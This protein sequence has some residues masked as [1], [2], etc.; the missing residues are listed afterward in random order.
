MSDVAPPESR[1]D[2][3]PVI[4]NEPTSHNTIKT[5]PPIATATATATATAASSSSS[6]SSSSRHQSSSSS[7]SPVAPSSETPQ[8]CE[9]TTGPRKTLQL[10]TAVDSALASAQTSPGTKTPKVTP[11]AT[12]ST[13]QLA[14]EALSTIP[15]QQESHA[16]SIVPAAARLLSAL[17]RKHK[18]APAIQ[19]PRPGSIRSRSAATT[20]VPPSL[21]HGLKHD[22]LDLTANSSRATTPTRTPSG[23]AKRQRRER[24][25]PTPSA[26]PSALPSL[27]SNDRRRSARVAK[28]V[29]TSTSDSPN[30]PNLALFQFSPYLENLVINTKETDRRTRSAARG[31]RPIVDRAPTR[32]K[33]GAAKSKTNEPDQDAP[34][35]EAKAELYRQLCTISYQL[36]AHLDLMPRKSLEQLSAQFATPSPHENADEHANLPTTCPESAVPGASANASRTNTPAPNLNMQNSYHAQNSYNP[37]NQAN[38]MCSQQQPVIIK[39]EPPQSPRFSHL[40]SQ[41]T[42]SHAHFESQEPPKQAYSPESSPEVALAQR[43]RPPASTYNY[44]APTY[45]KVDQIQDE[46]MSPPFRPARRNI[47]SISALIHGPTRPTKPRTPSPQLIRTPPPPVAPQFMQEWTDQDEMASQ[48]L[49]ACIAAIPKLDTTELDRLTQIAQLAAFHLPLPSAPSSPRTSIPPLLEQD[50]QARLEAIAKY[51]PRRLNPLDTLDTTALYSAEESDYLSEM[52][53]N[54]ELYQSIRYLSSFDAVV[55]EWRAG[56]LMRLRFQLERRKAEID[57]IW[58][59]DRKLAW[60]TF[61]DNRARELYR[62]AMAEVSRNKWQAEMQLDLLAVYRRKTKGLSKLTKDILVPDLAGFEQ[63]EEVK[64]LYR[65]FGK[66]LAVGAKYT[67]VADPLVRADLSKMRD[68]IR[69]QKQSNKLGQEAQETTAEADADGA[70]LVDAEQVASEESC[71]E[72]DSDSSY[73]TSSSSYVTSSSSGISSLPSFSSVYSSPR[74][75]SIADFDAPDLLISTDD[76]DGIASEVASQIGAPAE[77]VSDQDADESLWARQIRLTNQLAA[78]NALAS[79]VQ[80]PASPSAVPSRAT[81]PA[82]PAGGK[83]PRG[84]KRKKRPPPPGARLWKKGR[85]QRDL[86]EEGDEEMQPPPAHQTDQGRESGYPNG[87]SKPEQQEFRPPTP[88]PEELQDQPR[89]GAYEPHV[90][91][92]RVSGELFAPPSY[93][94]PMRDNQYVEQ[95]MRYD[96]GPYYPVEGATRASYDGGYA[97]PPPPA[98]PAGVWS[99]D[100]AMAYRNSSDQGLRY[101]G[102][103]PPP[104]QDYYP[105]YGQPYPHHHQEQQDYEVPEQGACRPSQQQQQQQQPRHAQQTRPQWPY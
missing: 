81:T 47:M 93:S 67:D 89:N 17:H 34:D 22:S 73:V 62:G 36:Q 45:G 1:D 80:T 83:K 76:L 78:E 41:Y 103:T 66:F 33:R 53:G 105:S 70:D 56:E 11:T 32:A 58:A 96:E 37:H 54:Q 31:I 20:P 35:D 12:V 71:Y 43:V 15:Q 95:G 52:E 19:S 74:L 91:S 49:D 61:I 100:E 21:L 29:T 77:S 69:S 46:R 28:A 42:Q 94:Y 102:R 25:P 55:D 27:Q 7:S 98:A 8:R 3:P 60:S 44:H 14:S 63:D 84:T 40:E 50:E 23:R 39:A 90:Y 6:S 88:K 18:K 79:G 24:N 65:K 57:R 92:A 2:D 38:A 75:P 48:F 85:V 68:A 59:C 4:I 97:Y 16:A 82:P 99:R 87:A 5:P 26:V 104:P 13:L 10:S 72:S 86:T 64:E 9:P 51:D 30:S 101:T